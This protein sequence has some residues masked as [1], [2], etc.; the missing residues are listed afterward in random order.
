MCSSCL[1]VIRPMRSA[2][3]P[4]FYR[5]AS[6]MAIF[7]RSIAPFPTAPSSAMPHAR[8]PNPPTHTQQPG[9]STGKSPQEDSSSSSGHNYA[10]GLSGL[11]GMF[12]RFGL[13]ANDSSEAGGAHV[14]FSRGGVPI[15]TTPAFA[16]TPAHL[17]DAS[18]VGA[19]HA[20]G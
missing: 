4:A 5:S 9:S 18:K 6:D 11:P 8:P 12:M 3:A 2:F 1:L 17:K 10:L 7:C 13:G 19:H 20:D 14:R 16:L 15:Y